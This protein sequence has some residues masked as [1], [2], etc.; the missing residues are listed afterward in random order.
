[1]NPDL[2]AALA[3]CSTA[4]VTMQLI[5]RGIRAS[6]MR[7]VQPLAPGQGRI[8]GAAYTVR[9][10]PMREDLSDPA[11]L[12]SP[13][14]PQRIAIEECPEGAILC[15]DGLGNGE[16]GTLGDILAERLRVRGVAAAVTDSATRDAQA[17]IATGF[18]V[19]CNGRAAPPNIT[20]L[21]MGD[22]QVPI[23]CGGVAVIPGDVLVCDGD[24]VV[25][26]P[27][28]LAEEVAAGAVE[29]ERLEAFVQERI[30]D[31]FTVTE[32]YPPDA[33][34]LAAYEAWKER[35]ESG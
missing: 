19:W 12:G 9:F 21:A 33:K 23:G 35:R 14:N 27:Q 28:A 22:R 25:V 3:G 8:V 24:G 18:P 17:V 30:R 29:Q 26:I 10:I 31:G 11:I 4:T 7:G 32:S 15:M 6:A 20:G 5:K 16:V 13:D 1:M 2:R 34:T